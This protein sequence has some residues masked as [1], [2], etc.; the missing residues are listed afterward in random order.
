MSL[1]E[2]RIP[3]SEELDK[4]NEV[5]LTD[6]KQQ[7]SQSKQTRSAFP[8]LKLAGSTKSSAE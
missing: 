2:K 6:V 7:Q 3:Q 4:T 1:W 8:V 5:I